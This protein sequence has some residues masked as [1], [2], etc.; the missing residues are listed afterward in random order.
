MSKTEAV[1][2]KTEVLV[3]TLPMSHI[4]QVSEKREIIRLVKLQPMRT[5]NNFSAQR[6]NEQKRQ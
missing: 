3:A 4:A 6:R 1:S 5:A 2:R